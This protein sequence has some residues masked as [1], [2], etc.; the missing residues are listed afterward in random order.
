MSSPSKEKAA[1]QLRE[2]C[3]GSVRM[4]V[5]R[6]RPSSARKLAIS[7]LTSKTLPEEDWALLL[8]FAIFCIPY[9]L[10]GINLN[11]LGDSRRHFLS[12][13]EFVLNPMLS[14]DH[15]LANNSIF[16]RAR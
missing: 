5:V 12:E 3:V 8:S 14:F 1:P 9:P 6:R 2:S 10:F 4:T 15:R 16:P 13:N 11:C 7:L